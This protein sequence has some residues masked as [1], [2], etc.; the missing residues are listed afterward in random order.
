MKPSTTIFAMLI[1]LSIV[2]GG[3]TDE[4]AAEVNLHSWDENGTHWIFTIYDDGSM[5]EWA[6]YADGRIEG[7]EI[8]RDDGSDSGSSGSRTTADDIKDLARRSYHGKLSKGVQTNN[9]FAIKQSGSGKG[10]A[11]R[12]NPPG[13]HSSGVDGT[14]GSGPGSNG[15]GTGEWFKAMAKK[16]NSDDGDNDSGKGPGKRPELGTNGSIRPERVNPVPNLHQHLR[17]SIADSRA[18]RQQVPA[19]GA[20][21]T[22]NLTT[23]TSQAHEL[24]RKNTSLKKR[25]TETPAGKT[26]ASSLGVKTKQGQQ[27]QTSTVAPPAAKRTVVVQQFDRR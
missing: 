18:L 8:G 23:V 25:G 24:Q 16:G 5:Y 27:L 26:T 6:Y 2:I 14:T 11:P 17:Q 20:K 21:G 9:P 15:G 1:A 7:D 13:R 12:W 22:K 3:T 10:L 19:T 4:C